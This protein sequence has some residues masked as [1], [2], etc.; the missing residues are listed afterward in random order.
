MTVT[1]AVATTVYPGEPAL[2]LV[3]EFAHLRRLSAKAHT[4]HQVEARV[5]EV[6]D[7]IVRDAT[8]PGFLAV[9][10]RIGSRLCGFGTAVRSAD[11]A[12]PHPALGVRRS[13]EWLA[14]GVQV[15]DLT[16]APD[17]RDRTTLPFFRCRG[18]RQ[19]VF[20]S[21][22]VAAA[23]RTPVVFLAPRH[24]ALTDLPAVP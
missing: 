14:G 1:H 16:V 19:A 15:T 10:A 12:M 3:E 17:A 20:P 6:R 22:D 9:T 24:P 8:A 11:R 2:V 13:R 5:E 18:W 21:A 4:P 23:G 7:R